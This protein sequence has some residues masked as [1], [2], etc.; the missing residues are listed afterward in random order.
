MPF[1]LAVITD[2]ISQDFDRALAVAR[3]L[4][5]AQVELRGMW[6]K[7]LIDLT[8][9][10]VK[11][12]R[13][14]LTK[15][16][17]KVTDLASPFLKV[18]APGFTTVAGERDAFNARFGYQEQPQVLKRAIEL[19]KVFETDKIRIFSFWRV[20]RPA[21]VFELIVADIHRALKVAKKHQ[22]T[23]I[24]EN[25]HACNIATAAESVKVLAAIQDAHFALTWDPANAFAAGEKPFPDGYY[26]LP[27]R[28]I[29]HVHVKDVARNSSTGRTE[30][31][32]MGKG[33]V[34][35]TGQFKAL[36]RDRY[37][38]SISLETH[39]RAPSGSAEEST[40]IS[41][42]GLKEL[43]VKAGAA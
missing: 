15:Y 32:P 35:Y 4:G 8:S 28:R 7:N 17:M 3:E 41:M 2:E 12:A 30:W 16:R 1:K 27:Q 26:L 10:E 6:G 25:E 34:D 18:D 14:L 13:R 23:L 40:R 20:E 22:I 11:E 21:E 19:A 42:Q 24:L 43:L 39:W 9:D 37:R 36:V 5:L 29:A 38:H 33:E 31:Q